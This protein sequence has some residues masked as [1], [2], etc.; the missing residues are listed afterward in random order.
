MYSNLKCQT[1]KYLK[2][3]SNKYDKDE[4]LNRQV[5]KTY[6]K[7]IRKNCKWPEYKYTNHGNQAAV[8]DIFHSLELRRWKDENLE[9]KG[10]E[11]CVLIG[12]GSVNCWDTSGNIWKNSAVLFLVI[13]FSGND[14]RKINNVIIRN[15]GP[16]LFT[17]VGIVVKNWKQ[18]IGDREINY[19]M[20]ILW[21]SGHQ[22]SPKNWW[23][24]LWSVYKTFYL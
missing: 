20:S 21:S 8:C 14:S 23:P 4:H 19:C 12:G 9:S 13:M 18:P 6:G 17:L 15:L 5:R 22:P 24:L 3:Y 10:V 2:A 1:K 16:Q 7:A 11:M